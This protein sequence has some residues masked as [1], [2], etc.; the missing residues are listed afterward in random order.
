MPSKGELIV[1]AAGPLEAVH[2]VS[3]YFSDFMEPD[4]F[5]RQSPSL[6]VSHELKTLAFKEI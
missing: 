1:H 5:N 4:I 6:K 3:W 2:L